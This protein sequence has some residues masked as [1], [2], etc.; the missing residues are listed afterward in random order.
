[1]LQL[2]LS[3]IVALVV[4]GVI[5][6]MVNRFLSPY[7]Q[8]QILNMLNIAGVVIVALCL[9][10]YLLQMFGLIGLAGGPPVPKLR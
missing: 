2:A 7:M 3:V 5:L 8:P 6:W 10:F 4:I 1:M 9:L